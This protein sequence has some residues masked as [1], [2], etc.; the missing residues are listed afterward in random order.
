MFFYFEVIIF[1]WLIGRFFYNTWKTFSKFTQFMLEGLTNILFFFFFCFLSC[2]GCDRTINKTD[3]DVRW[4]RLLYSCVEELR[5]LCCGYYVWSH[6]IFA[7]IVGRCSWWWWRRRTLAWISLSVI[8][9]W[10][11][12]VDRTTCLSDVDVTLKL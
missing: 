9:L 1:L 11:Q 4:G 8:S 2:V 5:S 3:E 7:I 12:C 10:R 6:H